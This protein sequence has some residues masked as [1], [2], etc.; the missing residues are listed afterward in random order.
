[1]LADAEAPRTTR[2]RDRRPP[3]VDVPEGFQV[4]IECDD[5]DQQQAVFERMSGEG[6]KCRLLTL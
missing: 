3:E 6:F 5:E 2:P 1:M 4:V